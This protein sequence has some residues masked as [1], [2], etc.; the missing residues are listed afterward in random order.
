MS[1][2]HVSEA[3]SFPTRALTLIFHA[4]LCGEFNLLWK[5]PLGLM[6][7]LYLNPGDGH[8]ISLSSHYS[9]NIKVVFNLSNCSSEDWIS[10]WLRSSQASKHL[11]SILHRSSSLVWSTDLFLVHFFWGWMQLSKQ[12]G[13]RGEIHKSHKSHLTPK[14]CYDF[15]DSSNGC[16]TSEPSSALESTSIK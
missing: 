8:Q 14:T 11:F 10:S 13:F 4:C 1:P 9:Y 16:E 2:S 3:H 15:R 12:I 6:L 5:F 7:L